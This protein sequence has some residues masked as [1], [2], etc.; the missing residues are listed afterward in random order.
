[1]GLLKRYISFAHLDKLIAKHSSGHDFGKEE[2]MA[3]QHRETYYYKDS[4]GKILTIRIAGPNKQSTD[5]HFQEFLQSLGHSDM[6]I[7]GFIEDIYR[8][9]FIAP[10][11]PS[12]VKNYNEYIHYYI[13]PFLGEM[14]LDQINVAKI[15]QF[16]DWMAL[17]K[18]ITKGTIGRVGGLLSRM[19]KVADEMEL[20]EKSPFKPTL[21]RNHGKQSGHHTPLPDEEVARVKALIPSIADPRQRL[22]AALLVYT[23][24]RR[25]E[26]AGLRWENVH[27]EDCYGEIHR[28]VIYPGNSTPVIKDTPKTAS[29]ERFFIIPNQLKEILEPLRH[30]TGYVV[31]GLNLEDPMSYST[32]QRTYR[33]VFAFLG[34]EDYNNHD[35]RAT[36]GTQLKESGLTSAQV[37][38]L[39]GHADTRM[40]ET[41]YARSRKAGILKYKYAVEALD[42]PVAKLAADT[43]NT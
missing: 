5:L 11:S 33:K 24:M 36:Y 1:M 27:L 4:C 18:H 39:L 6:T 40:V 37:A 10:L 3:S 30:P 7:A 28:V 13:L 31:H 16:F 15:Q 26:I 19:L 2:E 14:R 12:T 43:E 20:V 38:D 22:Y 41:V 9:T 42:L 34:I 8:P 35:W 25:E 21:L 23:G 29:S 17:E 32:M